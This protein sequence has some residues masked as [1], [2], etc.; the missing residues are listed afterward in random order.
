MVAP[1]PIGHI[2]FTLGR[3]S[4]GEPEPL[5]SLWGVTLTVF[6]VECQSYSDER[7]SIQLDGPLRN[8]LENNRFNQ[9]NVLAFV[10][11]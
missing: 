7:L 10:T 11:C 6:L 5:C 4:H 1:Y 8:S 3:C 2:R 9:S